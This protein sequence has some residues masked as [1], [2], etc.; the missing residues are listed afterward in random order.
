VSGA[1]G[2]TGSFE[3]PHESRESTKDPRPTGTSARARPLGPREWREALRDDAERL[4]RT[5]RDLASY[6]EQGFAEI[7]I[8][9]RMAYRIDVKCPTGD[10][11]RFLLVAVGKTVLRSRSAARMRKSS[12][13]WPTI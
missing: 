11:F 7:R 5:Y 10:L 3:P 13:A 2:L 12:I 8:D 6:V 9:G 4:R 1:A